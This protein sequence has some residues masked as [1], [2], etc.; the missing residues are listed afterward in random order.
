[1]KG[2]FSKEFELGINDVDKNNKMKYSAYLRFMQ[3]IGALHSKEY[4]YCLDTENTTHKAWV[5]LKWNLDIF[6]RPSWNDKLYISTWLGKIDKIYFYRYFEIK[7][8]KD[9]IIAKASSKWIMVDTITRKIQKVTEELLTH[10]IKVE[11]DVTSY[12]I[13]KDNFKFDVENLEE[14][15]SCNVQKRDVDTNRTYE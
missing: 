9:E 8:E 2:V 12:D 10:F 13:K 5:V 6:M 4:G 14:I 7:N 3:E 11:K 15:Y 1:M